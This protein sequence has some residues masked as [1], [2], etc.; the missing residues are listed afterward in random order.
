MLSGASI[1]SYASSPWTG[2]LGTLLGAGLDVA[3]TP[4]QLE[5]GYDENRAEAGEKRIE[6]FKSILKDPNSDRYEQVVSELKQRSH[7]FWKH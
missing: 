6:Q 4:F 2:G 5:G 7:E 1:A 3:A